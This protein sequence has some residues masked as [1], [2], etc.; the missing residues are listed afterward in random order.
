MVVNGIESKQ[1]DG[2]LPGITLSPD[3]TRMAYRGRSGD[4][5]FSGIRE[6]VREGGKKGKKYDQILDQRQKISDIYEYVVFSP[7]S[8]HI[9]YT[10]LEDNNQIFVVAD[11][12]EGKKYDYPLKDYGIHN[13]SL[14]K[15]TFDTAD[16]FHYFILKH[17]GVYLVEERI[18]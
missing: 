16:S 8:R 15:I 13:F 10:V 3:F 2:R 7:D 12:N 17:D 6:Y 11:G 14:G 5:E 1:Y 4:E 9:A 18:E